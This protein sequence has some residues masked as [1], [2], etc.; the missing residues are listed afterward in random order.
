MYIVLMKWVYHETNE[1]QAS[2]LLTYT[3]FFQVPMYLKLKL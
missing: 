1:A 2:G 3:D